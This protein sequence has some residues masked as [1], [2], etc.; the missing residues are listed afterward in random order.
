[1]NQETPI[2][3]QADAPA[4]AENAAEMVNLGF[5]IWQ[6]PALLANS[7]W[8]VMAHPPWDADPAGS[9]NGAA[10]H[11]YNVKPCGQLVV[12]EPIEAEA[13]HGLFA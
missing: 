4:V 12:P 2:H 7:W 10:G 13:E 11:H 8:E 5:A 6:L 3:L 9:I 1:M